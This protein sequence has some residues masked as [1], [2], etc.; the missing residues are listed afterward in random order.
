MWLA[1]GGDTSLVV[2]VI[3][4]RV[5]IPVHKCRE[6]VLQRRFIFIAAKFTFKSLTE[7]SLAKKVLNYFSRNR[8]T[9]KG[10]SDGFLFGGRIISKEI[11]W[12]PTSTAS[13]PILD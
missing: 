7:V 3:T 9:R 2:G 6:T 8:I 5:V 4:V 12:V 1:L 11:L 10:I 13:T